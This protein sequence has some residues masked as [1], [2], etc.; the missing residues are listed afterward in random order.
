MV[1]CICEED[2]NSY[3][4][5]GIVAELSIRHKKYKIFDE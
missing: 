1:M 5:V 4:I 2:S 3:L